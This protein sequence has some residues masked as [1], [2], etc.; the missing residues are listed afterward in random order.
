[1]WLKLKETSIK[2]NKKFITISKSE[3]YL[4]KAQNSW[5]RQQER[6]QGEISTASK[7]QHPIIEAFTPK[8]QI[9]ITRCE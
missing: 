6:Q 7:N 3:V 2:Y 4:N 9:H 1:M 8:I 5:S